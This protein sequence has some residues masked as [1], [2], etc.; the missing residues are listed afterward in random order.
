MNKLEALR[1]ILKNPKSVLLAGLKARE[2]QDFRKKIESK[3]NINQLPTIDLLE[4]FPDLSENIDTYSFLNGTSLITDMILLKAL[5]RKFENCAYLE[6]GS[7]RGESLAN[8]GDI[9]NDLTSLTLSATEMREMGIS[10]KFIS[11]HG[12]FSNGIG[13]IKKIENNSHTYD[14]K[15]LDKKFDLIFVD[16]DHS[17]EGVVNDSK[18]V[19][20]LR[21]DGNSI[22]V[23]HDYG[24]NTEDVRYSTLKGILDG[25]PIEKHRN[26]YHISNTMCAIY[27]EDVKLP[28]SYT[29]FPSVPNKVFSLSVTAKKI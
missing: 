14:F 21:K 27:I 20:P 24:F 18:K 11:V 29:S 2:Q 17:Y 25:I 28:T 23:W 16:G 4:L 6:I 3:Y 5:A 1:L 12:V 13:S 7:W 15:Q 8:V 26:L 22:I 19:F 9:T 10:E